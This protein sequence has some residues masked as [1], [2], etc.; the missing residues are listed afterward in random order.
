[1]I[2]YCHSPI[3]YI[4]VK[5]YNFFMFD[6]VIILAGGSGTR[7]WPASS[8]RLPKQFLPASEN[9]S[10]FSMALERAFALT[11]SQGKVIIITGKSHIKHV[12]ADGAKFSA[13][14][15]KRLIVI[16]EPAAKN[17]APAI[18]C[19]V[20]FSHF[21][22]AN[23][24]M[25]ILTSDHI[26][27]PLKTFKADASL[28]AAAAKD[29]KLTSGS[30]VVFGIPPSRPETGYGYIETDK[31]ASS[32][33]YKVA[34]FHEKPDAATAAKYAASFLTAE[35]FFW[36]SGMF[37]FNADFMAEQ[38]RLYAPDVFEC[39]AKLKQPKK[40]EYSVSRGVRVLKNWQGL[41]GA[42]KKTKSISFDYAIAEKCKNTAMIRA[43]FDWIDIGNWEEY[44]KI[45]GKNASQVYSAGCDTCYVDSD[46]PVALAGVED[47]I[48]VIRSGKDGSPA[49]ALITRKGQTQKVRDIVDLIKKAGKTELL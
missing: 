9:Q 15:K 20:K 25:L 3:A 48:V 37:A 24:N 19:A 30:L 5:F 36:N 21:C 29:G 18:A 10:F 13:A 40:S 43:N 26:I 49:S 42:Y 46:I 17:T 14:E 7:L 28:A 47:L 8:S 12:I 2:R 32:N 6:D 45:L 39:F 23:R 33:V 34:A 22:G 41:T 44:V 38:F 11:G 1:M 4:H 31:D 35:N 16:S 27:K